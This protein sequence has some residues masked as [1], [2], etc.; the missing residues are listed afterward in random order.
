MKSKFFNKKSKLSSIC[1]KVKYGSD[2]YYASMIIAKREYPDKKHDSL[3]KI[4]QLYLPIL[5][6]QR[7]ALIL[8][9]QF[10]RMRTELKKSNLKH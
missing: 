4:V 9:Q 6:M 3:I 5:E 1:L 10:N 7:K 8:R 2:L